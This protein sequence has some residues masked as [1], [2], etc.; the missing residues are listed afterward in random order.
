MEK[1]IIT[2]GRQCGSGGHTIGKLVA[3]RLNVPF[4]DK[5][6]VKIVAERS[7]LSE[8]AVERDGEYSPPSLLYNLA[9]RGV[10]GYSADHKNNMVL[11]DQINAYQTELIHE[12]AEQGPCVIVGRCADHILS[13]RRDCL[14]VFVYGKLED[15][16][17]RV[18][19]EHG[20]APQDA[21]RH[22]KERDKKRARYY[23][24]LTEQTWG[25][26]EN[27]NLCLDTSCLGI[28]HCVELI[29]GCAK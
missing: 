12:L 7:G 17:A 27:Y 4:Y 2:I 24:Y 20:I 11:H 14:H 18:V 29:A 6:L 9:A 16:M 28:E 15:R 13:D 5:Q 23:K 25:A 22:V 21:E 1:K 19:Q 10:S 3:E 8:K 26:A